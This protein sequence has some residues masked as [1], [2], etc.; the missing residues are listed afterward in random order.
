MTL[1][2]SLVKALYSFSSYII[3]ML[4]KELIEYLDGYLQLSH[5]RWDSNKNG[6]QVQSAKKSITKIGYAVD[7]TTYIFQKAIKENVD[8]LITHH[9]ILWG[10]EQPVTGVMYER[11]RALFDNEIVL[12]ACHLPLDAHP[13]IGNNNSIARYLVSDFWLQDQYELSPFYPIN[14]NF[15]GTGLRLEKWIRF[16]SLVESLVKFG[17]CIQ[18][19]NF[20]EKDIVR[21]LAIVA[22]A[23]GSLLKDQQLFHW[24]DVFV[25]GEALHDALTF[26]KESKQSVILGGHYETE[27]IGVRLLAEHLHE[28]F[29]LEYVFLDEKY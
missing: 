8:F 12:Y 25:T 26:A 14:G 29:E 20:G 10:K 21:S 4:Q 18:S 6:V 15:V 5:P 13:E 17:C 23:G 9:G 28:K 16:S 27:I 24:Y 11:V 2:E 22:G 3:T 7:A 1:Q 19:F